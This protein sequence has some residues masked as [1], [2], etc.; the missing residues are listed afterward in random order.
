MIM[1]I[2]NVHVAVVVVDACRGIGIELRQVMTVVAVI[3][4]WY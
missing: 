1:V 4:S 3:V 2:V